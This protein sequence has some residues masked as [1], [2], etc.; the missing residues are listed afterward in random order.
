MII[1]IG[2][3]SCI[4]IAQWH[5]FKPGMVI[6]SYINTIVLV[7]VCVLVSLTIQEILPTQHTHIQ[8]NK[9]PSLLMNHVS[10]EFTSFGVE[11][12]G[13]TVLLRELLSETACNSTIEH[14]IIQS[15][16]FCYE[17]APRHT[18]C[19]LRYVQYSTANV[20]NFQL[21]GLFSPQQLR[22][23]VC[24]TLPPLSTNTNPFT[25]TETGHTLSRPFKS[26]LN[27]D[28]HT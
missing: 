10:P 26:P 27:Q 5:Y 19:V 18:W 11:C 23:M 4:K 22:S 25:P 8:S 1:Y 3:K 17:Y 6:I 7:T 28:R 15:I 12:L 21:S 20:I 2:T 13:Y 9:S 24:V 16:S 14:A